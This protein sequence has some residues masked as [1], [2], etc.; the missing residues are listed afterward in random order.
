MDNIWEIVEA[1]FD[2]G[3]EAVNEEI[4]K[5]LQFLTTDLIFS[6]KELLKVAPWHLISTRSASFAASRRA[7]LLQTLQSSHAEIVEKTV[8]DF[9]QE[10]KAQMLDNVDLMLY[11]NKKLEFQHKLN[12]FIGQKI[13][14]LYVYR[15]RGGEVVLA[16]IETPKVIQEDTIRHSMR[17]TNRSAVL[18]AVA[19]AREKVTAEEID[20][21]NNLKV[22]YREVIYRS[23][24]FKSKLRT[25]N[26][27]RSEDARITSAIVIMWLSGNTWQRMSVSSVGDIN[28]A[29][30]AFYLNQ[31]FDSF[32]KDIEKNVETFMTD[33]D[34]GVAAVKNI[35]GLLEGDVNI[36]KTAYAIKSAGA[37]VLGDTDLLNIVATLATLTP[38]QLTREL[39]EK[40]KNH[41]NKQ[42]QTSRNTVYKSV[43]SE[44]DNILTE[45][46]DVFVGRAKVVT[47]KLK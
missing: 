2:R 39:V 9:Y 6:A 20:K 47:S 45:L 12:L 33:E 16:E 27:G 37:S 24:Q 21:S 40:I 26:K 44:I 4:S 1:A 13:K 30:A 5:N 34:N 28:E 22:T 25:L 43:N 42:A 32:Q 18:E 3:E 17:Y 36:G 38:D 31:Q 15:G 14:T 46:E 19:T 7:K 8:E 29:Y 41:L 23:N 35:S 10:Q 11:T